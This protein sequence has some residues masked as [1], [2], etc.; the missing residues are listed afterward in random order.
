MSR[1][2][3]PRVVK[4]L[5]R[6]VVNGIR[7][8][9]VH[10]GLAPYRPG[11]WSRQRWN[12]N[13]TSGNLDYFD[14]CS[15]QPRYSV[16]VGYLAALGQSRHVLDIG[17]GQGVLFDRARHLPFAR[18]SGVDLAEVAVERAQRLADHR[19]DFTTGD[20]L[21]S[22]WPAAPDGY[23]VVMLNEVLNMC[24]DPAAMLRRVQALLSPGGVLLVS[25]WHHRGDRA[26][27]K[28]IHRV[29][30]EIDATEVRSTTSKLA[31]R[32]WRVAMLKAR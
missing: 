25:G 10:V 5:G 26:L 31:P 32:G 30:D 3:L 4:R 13:Y 7:P 20:L 24:D 22:A 14:S 29:F 9:A 18:W 11:P 21:D 23:D 28:L 15:E 16:L 2:P 12:D 1:S 27:W 19:G 6:Q 17:C 8:W